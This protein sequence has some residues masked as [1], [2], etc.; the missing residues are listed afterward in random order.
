MTEKKDELT[1][2]DHLVELRRRLFVTIILFAIVLVGGFFVAKPVYQYLTTHDTNHI[3]LQLNAFSFWDGVNVYMKIALIVAFGIM[4][5]FIMYQLWAF[6]SPGLKPKERRATLKYI[7]FVFIC[8]IAGAAFGYYVVFPLAMTFTSSLNKQL[9][10]VETYGIADYLKFMTNI[11]LP[12]ALLFELPVV[13]LFLTHLRLLNPKRLK[14]MRRVAYFALVVLSV[15][16]TPPDFFSAFLVLIP[17]ILLYEFSVMLSARIHTKQVA[18]DAE[19]KAK[20][21]E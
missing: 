10:L 21:E 4:L 8:F 20:Y 17:M 12:I 2:V 11:I 13:V 19:R 1:V 7:P 14:K 5:P 9:G 3:V 16:I 15:M 18:S 6:V